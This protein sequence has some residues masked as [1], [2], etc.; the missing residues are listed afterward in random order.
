M[1]FLKSSNKLLRM[2]RSYP[3]F[4]DVIRENTKLPHLPDELWLMIEDALTCL[5]I[6]D[7]ARRFVFRCERI[8]PFKAIYQVPPGSRKSCDHYFER[9]GISMYVRRFTGRQRIRRV[10]HYEDPPM[11]IVYSAVNGV[12]Y[13][14]RMRLLEARLANVVVSLDEDF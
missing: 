3:Y 7:H 11:T 13:H 6:E 1:G 8:E 9:L 2:N 14:C 10:V 4:A 5:I 12:A